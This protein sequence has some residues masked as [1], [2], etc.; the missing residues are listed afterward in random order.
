MSMKLENSYLKNILSEY[1]ESESISMNTLDNAIAKYKSSK[2]HTF[3]FLYIFALF[4]L[5]TLIQTLI[6]FLVSKEV[7]DLFSNKT[8]TSITLFKFVLDYI[9]KYGPIL[10]LFG[11]IAVCI[12]FYQNRDLLD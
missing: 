5:F 7:F 11:F 12:T 2:N 8:S 10:A 3:I 4:A 9:I 1:P 6:S